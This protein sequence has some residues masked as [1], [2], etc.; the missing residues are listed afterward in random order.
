[1]KTYLAILAALLLL[2]ACA[3]APRLRP[4]VDA[5]WEARLGGL[6]NKYGKP[7]LRERDIDKLRDSGARYHQIT[8]LMALRSRRGDRVFDGPSLA[9][10]IGQ[11]GTFEFAQ[12]LADK[13]GYQFTGYQ[14]ATLWSYGCNAEW[15]DKLTDGS[16]FIPCFT[17]KQLLQFA[18]LGG[19]VEFALQASETI[20]GY[21]GWLSG[22]HIVRILR[23][24]ISP[25]SLSQFTALR[26]YNGDRLFGNA[27]N[28]VRY[29]EAGGNVAYADSLRGFDGMSIYRFCQLGISAAEALNFNDT[30]RPN[31]V[32]IFTTIDDNDEFESKASLRLFHAVHREYDIWVRLA[33]SEEK[34][35][36][37]VEDV[38]A[39]DLLWIAGHGRRGSILLGSESIDD[40]SDERR[41]L[42]TTDSE[43][44]DVL[45]TLAPDATIFLDACYTDAP[46]NGIDNLADFIRG[47]APGRTVVAADYLFSHEHIHVR[48]LAPLRLEFIRP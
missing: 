18:E 20:K 1:M 39:A 16:S 48:S 14:I 26:N 31:A 41:Y 3:T 28:L 11:K 35:A 23:L 37:I 32:A 22:W 6:R 2:T 17:S 40:L 29:L 43:F 4:P 7:L 5:S 47:L 25:Q 8:K 24:G 19:T 27:E 13:H 42:D 44:A 38:P 12:H 15:V 36:A 10:Y 46:R 21:C 9:W 34:L 33:D 45:A 30:P